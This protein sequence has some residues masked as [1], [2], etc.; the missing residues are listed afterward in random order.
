ME[1][2]A[3]DVT[4]TAINAGTI[5]QLTLMKE[6]TSDAASLCIANVDT[7]DTATNGGDITLQWNGEGILQL[8]V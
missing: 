7:A 1:L 6:I 5:A 8:T 3:A 4:W 2:D